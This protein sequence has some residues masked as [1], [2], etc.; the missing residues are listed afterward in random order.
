MRGDFI[1]SNWIVI[2]FLFYYIGIVP[3]SPKFVL[4]LGLIDNILIIIMMI[5]NGVRFLSIVQFSG[6]VFIM[7]VI[8]L[9]LLRNQ[10]LNVRD[11]IF[12]LIIIN[13]YLLWLRVNGLNFYDILVDIRRSLL[14]DKAD[15]PMMGLFR[16]AEKYLKDNHVF[17]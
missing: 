13:I 9:L 11:I 3:Y 5:L 2:W 8:P 16:K 14:G 7:K 4:I 6:I 15:T 10:T 1:F 12:T 17:E